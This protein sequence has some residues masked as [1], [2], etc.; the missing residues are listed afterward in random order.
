M[1]C[2]ALS[3]EPL[4]GLKRWAGGP[5]FNFSVHAMGFRAVTDL[6]EYSVAELVDLIETSAALL[7]KKLGADSQ[8]SGA[9]S[10][11]GF[12]VIGSEAGEPS[13][14]SRGP[15]GLSAQSSR[16]TGLKSPFQCGYHCKFCLVQCCRPGV[17][18]NHACL[19]HRHRR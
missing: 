4:F 6:E 12:S 3:S 16:D 18:Q 13:S 19:E 5:S 2:C 11:S 9:E 17:H 14:S 7:K 1:K 8:P 10:L 15:P